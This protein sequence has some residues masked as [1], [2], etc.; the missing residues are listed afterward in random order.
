MLILDEGLVIL[1]TAMN[2]LDLSSRVTINMAQLALANA[3]IVV[4]R[5]TKFDNSETTLTVVSI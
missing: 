3:T 2:L 5:N 1:R 4:S